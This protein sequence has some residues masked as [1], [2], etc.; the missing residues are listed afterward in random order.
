MYSLVGWYVTIP[1][2][3]GRILFSIERAGMAQDYVVI[4]IFMKV[5]R[6]LNYNETY[7]SSGRGYCCIIQL[8]SLLLQYW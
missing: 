1:H 2:G 8:I 7:T 5:T 6:A 4:L 3:L